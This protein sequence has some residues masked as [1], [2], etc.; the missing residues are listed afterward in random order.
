[1][2]RKLELRS[3][4]PTHLAILALAA[5]LGSALA[6]GAIIDRIAVTVG[7]R[8]ITS[9]DIER[10]VRVTAFLNGQPPDLSV[11]GKRA[12]VERMVEQRLVRREIES[13][14]YPAPQPAEIE[15]GLA[16]FRKRYYPAEADYRRALAQCGISDQD[17]RDALLWQRTLLQ[18]VDVRFRPAVQISAEEIRQYFDT[19]LAPR[20]RA[21]EPSRTV[22]LEDY[23]DQIEDTLAGQREDREMDNW[24]REARRQTPIVYHDEA[25]Q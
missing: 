19:V 23:R 22:S 25:F 17:V 14:R 16:A 8:A 6:L 4:A 21:A 15:P 7:N 9:S 10:E 5:I 13:S 3:A 12:A 24:L 18:F 2:K 20:L 11:A 1:L